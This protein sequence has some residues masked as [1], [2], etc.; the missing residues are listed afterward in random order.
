[1]ESARKILGRTALHM[2]LEAQATSPAF[3]EDQIKE[4]ADDLIRNLDRRLWE[5]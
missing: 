1:L 5:D 2:N 4:T 3:Q